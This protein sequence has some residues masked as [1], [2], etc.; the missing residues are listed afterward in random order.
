MRTTPTLA[1]IQRKLQTSILRNDPDP[2]HLADADTSLDRL[3]IYSTAYRL[4]LQEAL[5]ANFPMLCVHLSRE[6]FDA[7]ALEYLDAHPSRHVSVRAFGANLPDWLRTQHADEPWLAEFARLEWALGCAFDAL[8][9]EAVCVETLARIEPARWPHLTFRFAPTVHRLTLHTNAA[10]LY[11]SAVKE[12]P[13]PAGVTL[14][15]DEWLAYRTDGA[16]HYRSLAANEA[17][18][19]DVVYGDGTFAD[20]CERLFA[21]T[22]EETVSMQAAAFLKRWLEDELIVAVVE[23]E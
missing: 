8:D 20:A 14:E 4:R 11:A 12:Q 22:N 5:A 15:A 13:A 21:L 23:R 9:A 6:M 18:A 1:A 10:A 7:L 2:S 3:S 17:V 19:F 16:A